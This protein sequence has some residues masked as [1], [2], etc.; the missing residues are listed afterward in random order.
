M[1]DQDARTAFTNFCL[2]RLDIHRDNIYGLTAEFFEDGVHQGTVIYKSHTDDTITV[3]LLL[4]WGSQ[5][6]THD[7]TRLDRWPGSERFSAAAAF[8]RMAK[9]QSEEAERA[10]LEAEAKHFLNDRRADSAVV[11]AVAES[12]AAR[13]ATLTDDL[14]SL[15]SRN[16]GEAPEEDTQP[17]VPVDLGAIEITRTPQLGFAETLWRIKKLKAELE[18]LGCTV[19][20]TMTGDGAAIKAANWLLT[21][22]PIEQG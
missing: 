9:K 8:E 7:L 20:V 3:N 10:R 14:D 15:L 6:E 11:Q 22:S 1:T 18:S 4:V 12:W 17:G 19:K 13:Q 21:Q 5:E 2:D 16:P